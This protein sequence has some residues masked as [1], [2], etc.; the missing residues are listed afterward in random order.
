MC[1]VPSLKYHC[2]FG[3]KKPFYSG[4]FELW[5]SGSASEPRSS[6]Q[7]VRSR[8]PWTSLSAGSG[9]FAARLLTNDNIHIR[10]RDRR[11]SSALAEFYRVA[12]FSCHAIF[13]L[14]VFLK[15]V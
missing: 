11:A 12:S 1:P 7:L 9:P 15:S 8:A 13:I 10:E 5:F 14:I 3:K 6:Q 2:C 4:V